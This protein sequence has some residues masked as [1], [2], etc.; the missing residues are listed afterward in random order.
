MFRFVRGRQSTNEVD[1]HRPVQAQQTMR[2]VFCGCLIMPCP[3]VLVAKRNFGLA[4]ENIIAGWLSLLI[5]IEHCVFF[6]GSQINSYF[7]F[8]CITDHVDI[9]S[10]L[11][12]QSIG[13]LC[14]TNV[15]LHPFACVARALIQ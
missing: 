4:G 9:F 5:R 14:Q 13:Q 2:R 7:L 11:I 10:V 6:H 15:F 3:D 8:N 12:V 1:R